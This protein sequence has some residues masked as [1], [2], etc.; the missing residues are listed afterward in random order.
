MY[1]LIIKFVD[2]EELHLTN[3]TSYKK[4]TDNA[5]YSV[6]KNGYQV[7]FNCD[8]VKYIGRWFDITNQEVKKK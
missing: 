2:G 6:M 1:D 3:V 4:F 5:V 7:F 8:Q